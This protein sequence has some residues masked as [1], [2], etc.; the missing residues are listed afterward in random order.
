MDTVAAY[1][2]YLRAHASGTYALIATPASTTSPGRTPWTSD[3]RRARTYLT[4]FPYGRHL[5]E[6]QATLEEVRWHD[7]FAANAVEAALG[8]IAAYRDGRFA[9]AAATRIDELRWAHAERLN[10]V[11]GYQQYLREQAAGQY[12]DRAVAQTDGLRWMLAASEDTV[13]AYQQY[14]AEQ[15]TGRSLRLPWRASRISRGRLPPGGHPGSRRGVP[16]SL[17]RGRRVEEARALI[18]DLQ[19]R[20]AVARG[21]LQ[22]YREYLQDCRAGTPRGRRARQDRRP[23]GPS[24]TWPTPARPRTHGPIRLLIGP[25]ST[26]TAAR[27][28]L[29]GIDQPSRPGCRLTVWQEDPRLGMA[30][31]DYPDIAIPADDLPLPIRGSRSATRPAPAPSRPCRRPPRVRISRRHQ[32]APARPLGDDAARPGSRQR[33][34]PRRSPG[35]HHPAGLPRPAEC[36]GPTVRFSAVAVER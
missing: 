19:W 11:D 9:A 33:R 29:R 32:P 4:A 10:T 35:R 22:A 27:I 6:A 30:V 2:G 13:A 20:A 21:T 25:R 16:G 15:P 1:E 24:Q 31:A 8:Y 34:V 17:A 14:L 18:D 12:R 7:A 3:G 36:D 26:I 23:P 5:D 28:S